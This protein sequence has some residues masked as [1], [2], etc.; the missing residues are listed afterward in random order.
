MVVMILFDD[1]MD[2]DNDM[3]VDIDVNTIVDLVDNDI[4]MVVVD[5]VVDT[6]ELV[7]ENVVV[8][9][10]CHYLQRDQKCYHPLVLFVDSVG[11]FGAFEL[12]VEM[13]L[14]N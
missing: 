3:V 7:V 1:D 12:M 2:M 10:I 14:R 13:D 8:V 4:D 5:N 9:L 11:H 6:V